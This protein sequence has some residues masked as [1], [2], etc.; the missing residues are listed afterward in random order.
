MIVSHYSH[1]V[2][3]KNPRKLRVPNTG[4]TG[5]IIFTGGPEI[6][7]YDF[8]YYRGIQFSGN[9][10]PHHHDSLGITESCFL[11]LFPMRAGSHKV[12]SLTWWVQSS[13]IYG[14]CPSLLLWIS[15]MGKKLHHLGRHKLLFYGYIT[16][17]T[18][19]SE[20]VENIF[21]KVN[22]VYWNIKI[23]LIIGLYIK[24]RKRKF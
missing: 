6:W 18:L 11:S 9:R 22:I 8:E 17:F 4:G 24:G 13:R 16:T 15:I 3:H 1:I 23:F 10:S 12:W 2:S 20:Q 7:H 5:L 14:F 19:G 21:R